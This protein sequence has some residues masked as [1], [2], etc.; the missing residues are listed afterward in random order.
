MA[1][2]ALKAAGFAAAALGYHVWRLLTKQG[3]DVDVEL[4]DYDEVLAQA[5]L[6]LSGFTVKPVAVLSL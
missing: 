1:V 6:L 3:S 4:E 5:S 2:G